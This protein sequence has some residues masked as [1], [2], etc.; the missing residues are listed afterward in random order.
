MELKKREFKPLPQMGSKCAAKAFQRIKDA[1]D[2]PANK[3]LAKSPY[4][5]MEI[6]PTFAQKIE[7]LDKTL[8]RNVIK[9]MIGLVGTMLI[10]SQIK[11]MVEE[12]RIIGV[13]ILGMCMAL[14]KTIKKSR[15]TELE[16]NKIIEEEIRKLI[17]KKITN[18][19]DQLQLINTIK[20][21]RPSKLAEVLALN[22]NGQFLVEEARI[23]AERLV[24]DKPR[25]H[26]SEVGQNNTKLPPV[27]RTRPLNSIKPEVTGIRVKIDGDPK[28]HDGE[29][30]LE[31]ENPIS[32][33]KRN[34]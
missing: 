17:S 24:R 10:F 23:E 32:M 13:A 31:E 28:E 18:T 26:V 33:A 34:S 21:R 8:D 1:F 3:S 16:Q 22:S 6:E 9:M 2:K 11:D 25:V 15:D 5:E 7:N 14:F 20:C 30:R 27:K 12:R 4:R 19:N 29:M